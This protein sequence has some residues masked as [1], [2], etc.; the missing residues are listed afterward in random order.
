MSLWSQIVA[1]S[2]ACFKCGVYICIKLAGDIP[3]AILIMSQGISSF[4]FSGLILALWFQEFHFFSG[5]LWQEYVCVFGVCSIGYFAQYTLTRGGQ[6]LIAG[7]ASLMRATDIAWSFLW[8]W[9]FFQQMPNYL[10]FIGATL[11]FMSV[12]LI[13][14]EKIKKSSAKNKELEQNLKNERYDKISALKTSSF[15][16]RRPASN[17]HS[18]N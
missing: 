17:K 11:M 9:L 3:A 13:T 18:I 1:I 14:L 8:G 2:S 16:Y 6:I 7:L 15:D 4:C 12:L 10:T 5:N